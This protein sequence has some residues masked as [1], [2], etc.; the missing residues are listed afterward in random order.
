MKS[1]LAET[2]DFMVLADLLVCDDG[3]E[4]IVVPLT[5]DVIQE[6]DALNKGIKKIDKWL[7]E[8]EKVDPSRMHTFITTAHYKE[9]AR[10]VRNVPRWWDDQTILQ[11]LE[12]I[13]RAKR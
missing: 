4:R 1:M 2:V 6:S 13:W 11:Q 3:F 8:H 5:C 12:N 10:I 9:T 7:T